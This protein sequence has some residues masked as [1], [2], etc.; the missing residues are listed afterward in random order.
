MSNETFRGWCEHRP[1]SGL[2]ETKLT[3]FQQRMDRCPPAS[4]S[5]DARRRRAERETGGLRRSPADT[6]VSCEL[7]GSRPSVYIYTKASKLRTIISGHPWQDTNKER[8]L[9]Q[10]GGVGARGVTGSWPYLKNS[11][12]YAI[13]FLPE[14]HL[15]TQRTKST[16]K[17]S[18]RR[19]NK[20]KKG[21]QKAKRGVAIVWPAFLL[22]FWETQNTMAAY[23]STTSVRLRL[24]TTE[25]DALKSQQKASQRP[26]KT[27][28]GPLTTTSMPFAQAHP[29]RSANCHSAAAVAVAAPLASVGTAVGLVS[30]EELFRR[31]LLGNLAE[32]LVAQLTV[33]VATR[34]VSGR[35]QRRRRR[36]RRPREAALAVAVIPPGEE[37]PLG[38]DDKGVLRAAGHLHGGREGHARREGGV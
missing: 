34:R 29:G 1:T 27:H 9:I 21:G 35:R 32:R 20:D 36:R 8:F 11:E 37:M 23:T 30:A 16:T 18:A 13:A 14:K 25:M 6:A 7:L 26:P 33:A 24:A 38:G 10:K 2:R 5:W 12:R 4:N 31:H 3:L 28:S 19:G 17:N 15:H 22:G